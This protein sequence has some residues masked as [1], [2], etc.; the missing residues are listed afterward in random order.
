MSNNI[1]RTMFVQIFYKV[2]LYGDPVKTKKV[3][4]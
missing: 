1:L 2:M 4:K 3:I